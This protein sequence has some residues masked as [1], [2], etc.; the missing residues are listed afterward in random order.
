MQKQSFS[1][2]LKLAG[3]TPEQGWISCRTAAAGTEPCIIKPG[4]LV[5][6][7]TELYRFEI[8]SCIRFS[9]EDKGVQRATCCVYRLL[10]LYAVRVSDASQAAALYE[11]TQICCCLHHIPVICLL[12]DHLECGH[13]E[14]SKHVADVGGV[15][16][17]KQ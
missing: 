6:I 11:L 4:R 9:T 8:P 17:D 3:P 14:M 13:H 5:T 2:E 12:C 15:G 10:L 1:T 7:P 16:E